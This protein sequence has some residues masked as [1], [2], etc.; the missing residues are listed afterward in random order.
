MLDKRVLELTASK[1]STFSVSCCWKG[2]IDG[3]EWVGT[4][5]YGPTL[6]DIRSDLW[7]ELLDVRLQ[8][9]IPWCVFG[10]FNVVRYP[11]ERRGCS[12]VSPSMVEFSNFIESQNL[13]DLPLMG[14]SYTWCNGAATPSMSRI[15][16]V[17]VSTEW[18]DHYPDV[19]QKLL[20]KPISDHYPILVEAGGMARGKTSFKFE[21][22]WLEAPD[23]VDKVRA[24]WSSYPFSGTPS[25]VLAQK[26]KALK[27]DLKVWNKQ[28]FGDVGIK[29]QQLECKL[30][31]LDG[32]ES[33]S[34]LSD[35]ERLR[36]EECKIEL[37]KVV[38][39]EEVSWRQKS[40]VLWLKEG[41]NNTKFFHK[42]ANSHRRYNYME[43]VE[44][45]GAVYEEAPEVREKV[46]QFYESLY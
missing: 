29:R 6:D 38:H 16:R 44:V 41:D 10:D 4:G 17:L 43:R 35:E 30:Q 33:E 34:S 27:G 46:V 9:P 23:F 2:I 20:P 8:W 39:M 25:F 42:M 40:R 12:R 28:V 37:E 7:A 31:F 15:D 19:V 3:F 5:V 26:L 18:E 13:V 32:K 45:D 1:V 22:M 21:N 14:G 36:R 11:S 24:W